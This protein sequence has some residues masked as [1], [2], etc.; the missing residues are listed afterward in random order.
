MAAYVHDAEG[1]FVTGSHVTRFIALAGVGNTGKQK[2]LHALGLQPA[3]LMAAAELQQT[4][5]GTTPCPYTLI[6]K[7]PLDDNLQGQASWEVFCVIHHQSH[8]SFDPLALL[9]SL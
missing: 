4:P 7:R 2:S 8:I 3:A 6:P 1:Y 9:L 5:A